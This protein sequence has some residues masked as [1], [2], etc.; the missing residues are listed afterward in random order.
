MRTQIC[1]T[2]DTEFSI[3][4]T[5]NDPTK[6]A[7]PVAEPAV[8]CY[9]NGKSH[10]LEFLLESLESYAAKATFFVE[11]VNTCY[12]EFDRMGQIAKRINDAGHDI[13]LHI[14][15]AW[16]EFR[17]GAMDRR[18][19]V[20]QPND[21]CANRDLK[22]LISIFRVGLEAFEYWNLPRPVAL[23]TGNMQV[24]RT[25]YIAQHALNIP[26]ASNISLPIYFPKPKDLH[27]FSGRHHIENVL[28][29]PVLTF[30]DIK[31]G[32]YQHLRPLQITAISI[33]E[34]ESVLWKARHL[35]V[36]TVVILTHPFEF[37]K[38]C[39]AQYTDLRRNVVNQQRLT[40]LC[41]FVKQHDE[42]FVFTTFSEQKDYWITHPQPSN[43]P[44][45]S[46]P[47]RTFGRMFENKINDLILSY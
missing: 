25:V 46:S 45:Q 15:P 12:F 36:E 7:R 2:I 20:W 10:G 34:M 38:R 41:R 26:L 8:Y 22:D 39:D 43:V 29:V 44:F 13:Q 11:A 24:D 3:C 35:G 40:S 27:L 28:E 16:I 42:D 21:S 6:G 18:D 31:V 19:G 23:R 14:H 9:V 47:I 30:F 17:D 32:R 33:K 5:F 37:V 4:S 1:L